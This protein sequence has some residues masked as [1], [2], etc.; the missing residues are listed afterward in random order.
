V[1]GGE[2]GSG[3]GNPEPD[4]NSD[5]NSKLLPLLGYSGVLRLRRRGGL[6]WSWEWEW[7]SERS[8]LEGD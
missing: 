5:L 4:L 8:W 1:W 6:G 3:G 2:R 7:E